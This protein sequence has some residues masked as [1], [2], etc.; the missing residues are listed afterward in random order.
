MTDTTTRGDCLACGQSQPLAGKL[1]ERHLV[2][3]KQPGAEQF[4]GDRWVC[5]GSGHPPAAGDEFDVTRTY[6]VARHVL[7]RQAATKLRS[8]M[9]S[10]LAVKTAWEVDRVI[11]HYAAATV[12]NETLARFWR[13]LV[14][15]QD[16]LYVVKDALAALYPGSYGSLIE[17]ATADAKACAARQFMVE[18]RQ[19]LQRVYPDGWTAD[20]VFTALFS[21]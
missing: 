8:E 19:E 7:A 15:A 3:E 5:N 14:S 17:Q 4:S 1:V 13:D 20:Q 16:P 18:V 11:Q 21:I 12:L 9:S 10:A 6:A 2:D